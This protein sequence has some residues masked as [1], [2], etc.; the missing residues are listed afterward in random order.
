VTR[1]R[2]LRLAA[3]GSAALLVVAFVVVVVLTV[4]YVRRPLPERGGEVALPGLKSSVQVVRDDRG[5]PQ[6]YAD[7]PLDLMR[8]QGYVHAQDR[9]FE[10]DLRRHITAGRLSE[11]VGA[12]DDALKADA[13][14]RTLG[15]RRVAQQELELVSPQV[16]SYLDAYADGV[17]DYLRGKSP[18]ELSVSYTLLGRRNT[19]P[20]I[21]PWTAVDSLAWIKAM[22]WDLRSNYEE[23]LERARAITTVKSVRRVGQLYPQYPYSEHSPIIRGGSDTGADGEA[24]DGTNVAGTST[25]ASAGTSGTPSVVTSNEQRAVATA[26]AGAAGAAGA[27]GASGVSATGAP[28]A[29]VGSIE[30]ALASEP[31]QRAFEATTAAVEA[32]PRLL[33]S[34]DGIGS[35]SWVLSGRLTASG[36]PL[37]ANDPHLDVSMPGIWYQVGL[38][39]RSVTKECPF[40]VAG[41]GFSGMPGVVVGHNQKI[42]WGMTNLYPDV[43]D[44]YL[45]RVNSIGQ[46]ESGGAMKPMT[47]RRET[48]EVAG[49]SPVTIT[50]RETPHGPLL[51]DVIDAVREVG[52]SAPA[53]GE[54]LDRQTVYG[55]SL[56]WTALTPGRAMDAIIAMDTSTN[57]DEF[58]R[59]AL[60]LD[61][62][63]QNMIYADVDG[64]IGYQ[65]P[66][67]IPIRGTGRPDG[68]EP[69]DQ[70]IPADGTWP[71]PGW[72]S[73]YDWRG[74]VPTDQL[75]WVRNPQEGYIVAANQAVTRPDGIYITSDWDY[76]Y[77]SDRI[78]KLITSG[79]SKGRKLT[80]DDMRA[81]Q[82]DTRNGIAEILV[83]TLLKVYD[84][85]SSRDAFTSEAVDL[86]RGWDYTQPKDSAA[87]AYF[88]VVWATILR[89]TFDELPEDFRPDGGDRWFQVVRTLMPNAK[90]A[91]W[92]DLTTPGVI[93]R[94]DE[95]LLR[96]LSGARL[97]LTSTL[98][99]DPDRWQWGRLHR[100]R[101]EQ[102]P[103]GGDSAPG[104]V[105]RL[106]NKGPYDAP[107]G[108]S[109]VN[110][111]SWD[112]A[113]GSF[114]V[115]AAP[116]MRMIVDLSD[117][118][119]SRWVNQTGVSGH[120]GDSHYDDQIG[121]W[122][123]GKDYAWPFSKSAVDR[124][125]DEEQ[126]FQPST[127]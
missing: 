82:S 104:L 84:Q 126:T 101:L 88:N 53:P 40:D 122:L 43:T 15:W 69:P 37:L 35:N 42:A 3:F 12:D 114:D 74:T 29:A 98:G 107:G 93:E 48:I 52:R 94:R 56:A 77:R 39:C 6:I 73:A 49:G 113:S 80:V 92:D 116:S 78:D 46:V 33:G 111:F 112:A 85:S 9:F 109:I 45:E 67:R 106:V 1:R 65:A 41:F 55:V 66:G 108:S 34:G 125:K 13:V 86:L 97:Q 61:A 91:W 28:A 17:N 96:A 54:E 63:A 5:V 68:A 60:L 50:V 87:A 79:V 51:S 72:D 4:T 81:I 14:V 24:S 11:L 47:T 27:S 71:Q 95:V 26:A 118:D 57:F 89:L 105:R 117:L 103:L 21:E 70:P 36:K 20:R 16:R 25:S 64:N 7:D 102:T 2:A 127:R 19:L 123:D 59:A 62:P 90:D 22:A 30:E 124:A 76:G 38:H 10:M 83:P 32:V 110:A 75:P 121:T 18:S 44:F 100:L 115:T 119:R 58:R 8:V 31:A 99:K 23:E 120:P